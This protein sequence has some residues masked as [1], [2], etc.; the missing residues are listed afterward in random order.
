[1]KRIAFL[2]F[3]TVFTR[4]LPWD[5]VALPGICHARCRG[6]RLVEPDILGP[7]VAHFP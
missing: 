1:M 2:Y 5:I 3:P 4:F 7:I 6:F